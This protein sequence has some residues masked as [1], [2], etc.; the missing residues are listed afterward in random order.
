[1]LD[2]RFLIERSDLVMLGQLGAPF[3]IIHFIF[4]MII[5]KIHQDLATSTSSTIL[6]CPEGFLGPNWKNVL[7]FW[8]YLDTLNSDQLKTVGCRYIKS[9][10][11]LSSIEKY[12]WADTLS[13]EGDKVSLASFIAG[14]NI[15]D[16]AGGYAADSVL[17]ATRELFYS[18]HLGGE[19]SF[20]FLPLFLN[21]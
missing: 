10:P 17:S 21:P 8:I 6:E 13:I 9:Y 16:R 18:Y 11:T 14:C 19:K 2:L 12:Y 20:V 7:N 3:L 15:S 5:S 4:I 1:M